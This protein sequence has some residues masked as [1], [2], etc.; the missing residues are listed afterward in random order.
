MMGILVRIQIADAPDVAH[1]KGIIHRDIQALPS[2]FA[3]ERG[4]AKVLDFPA[5]ENFDLRAGISSAIS[6]RSV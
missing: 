4:G 5:G 6:A 2:I 1:S 3:T